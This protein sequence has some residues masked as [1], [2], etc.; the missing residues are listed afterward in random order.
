MKY[1]K[2]S[3]IY[4]QNRE[5][6]KKEY[7]K[8]F[9]SISTYHLPL[10]IKNNEAFIVITTNILNTIE[11]I[12]KVNNKILNLLEVLPSNSQVQIHYARKCLFDE[13][14]L[15][16]DI[17]GVYSSRQ[18]LH[19]AFK[20]PNK[21]KR[22]NGMLNKY[23]RLMSNETVPLD[24]CNDIR[25]LYDEIVVN[26]IEEADRPDGEIFRKG[27]TSVYSPTEKEIHR[28]IAGE[29]K[30]IEHMEKLLNFLKLSNIPDL[31]KISV[32][33]YYFG[34][35]HPF[36]D[37]NGRMNRFISSYLLSKFLNGF[38]SLKISYAIKNS[39]GKYYDAF[40]Y[41]NDA[42]N[43][44]DLTP[45]VEMFLA[46]ISD[47]A[48]SA[49]NQIIEYVDRL[50]Y[51]E[52]LLYSKKFLN[53]FS[54]LELNVLFLLIQINMFD[55]EPVDITVIAEYANLSKN[56][57]RPVLKKLFEEK[58][59]FKSREFHSIVYSININYFEKFAES[60]K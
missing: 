56:S 28:G 60:L 48:H 40:I 21:K 7:D 29:D 13:V 4:Y 37:G 5:L 54:M 36:Y 53:T 25:T 51:F 58:F 46:I 55:G 49:Y 8:R 18:E 15:S 38:V 16:N 23:W 32:F 44:R 19:L 11:S 6:Y 50:K 20:N 52:D 1:S 30:I 27:V 59:I 39:I 10:S 45:F 9:N 41:G 34:Y 43:K 14:M 2:L 31:I 47:A 33:H 26:E 35:I 24:T 17:E 57:I 12:Y 22:F 42:K 3:S